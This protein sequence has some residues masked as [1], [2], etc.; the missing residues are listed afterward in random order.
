MYVTALPLRMPSTPVIA[1]IRR[2]LRLADN[3][4]LFHAAQPSHTVLPVYIWAPQEEAPWAPGGAQRWWL[5]HSLT[6]FSDALEARHSRLIVRSGPSLQALRQLIR[7]TGAGSVYWNEAY[8]PAERKRDLEI[9]QALNAQGIQVH[10]FEAQ[11]LHHPDHIRTGKGE[12]YKVF[13]PFWKNIRRHLTVPPPLDKPALGLACAPDEWPTSL[14]VKQL[15]LLPRHNWA[16]GIASAWTPGEAVAQERL[17]QFI[18]G[19]MAGYDAQRDYPGIAGTS[20]LSPHLHFG[21]ISAR[22]IWNTIS[23]YVHRED[24]T[25]DA[26]PFLRQLIWREFS[27][28]L[29]YHFPHSA[30]QNLRN[31]F[32]AFP[33]TPS[34]ETLDRWQKGQTGYPII[35]AGMRELWATGWMHNRVRMIVASFLTKHLL[36]HWMEGAKWFWDTLVDANLAN[37]TM[38]WQWAAGSGADAQPFFRIFNPILQG[39]K[40]DPKGVYVRTWIPELEA[41]PNAKIHEPWTLSP[42]EQRKASVNLGSTYPHPIVIHEEARNRAL[43]AYERIKNR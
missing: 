18:H 17:L 9:T 28:H 24:D 32:D 7:E 14:P 30:A 26:V 31:T 25:I 12:P 36:T 39:K 11:L 4:A 3:P 23:R 1:W 38:G 37:N 2:D 13:T 15:E 40:F 6:A 5:H 8:E 41:I 33:W 35:D 22:T 10:T 27:Y 34:S 43:A 20:R 16:Q 21:E 42:S 19:A 29:I